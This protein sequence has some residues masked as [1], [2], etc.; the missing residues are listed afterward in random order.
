MTV[1][2]PLDPKPCRQGSGAS[3]IY[4]WIRKESWGKSGPSRMG[5]TGGFN[6]IKNDNDNDENIQ[7]IYMNI[8]RWTLYI[9]IISYNVIYNNIT[10]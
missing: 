10:V 4:A 2:I 5:F 1:E 7:N 8:Y 9:H 3:K 6:Q